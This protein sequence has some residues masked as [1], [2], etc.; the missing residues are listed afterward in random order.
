MPF[1]AQWRVDWSRADHLTDS[2]E[3]I[4]QKDD[5]QFE[6]Y[7]WA[8]APSL[9]PRDRSRWTTVLG[10]FSYPC[11]LDTAGRGYVQPLGRVEQFIGPAVIYPIKRVPATPLDVFTVVDVVRATLGVGPC[12]YILDVEGQ[13]SQYRGCATCGM[14]DALAAI[15][16]RHQQKQKRDEIEQILRDVVVFVEHIR[17]RIDDYVAFGHELLAYLDRQKQDRPE[18]AELIGEFEAL[19]RSIDEHVQAR[20][21]RI[22]TPGYVMDLTDEFRRT[23]LDYD[24][25]DALSRCNAITHAVVEVGGNQDELVG[26]CR[27]VVKALRQRAGLAVARE[28][29]A[30]EIAGEIRRRTQQVLRNPAVHESAR[31]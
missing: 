19:A 16:G 18:L 24:G 28:P 30:A 27:M 7:G 15:Y 2:W 10:T 5:G 21:A 20:R 31:H 23:L 25:D 11:W 29:R 14:R 17:G 6:K 12:E 1:A 4:A 13:G 22:K 3:M 26:E 9:I 8:D